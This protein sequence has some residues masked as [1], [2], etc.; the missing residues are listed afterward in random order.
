MTRLNSLSRWA[1]AVAVIATLGFAA[2]V[3]LSRDD[4]PSSSGITA[5]VVAIDEVRVPARDA[6]QLIEFSRDISGEGKVVAKGDLLGHI[7][8]SDLKIKQKTAAAQVESAKNS[9]KSQD[10]WKAA[11]KTKEL[12]HTEWKK[13]LELNEKNPRTVANF[14]VQRQK[15][16]YDKAGHEENVAAIK[17]A[18]A[19]H[20]V[21]EK[22]AELEYV[23]NQISR[24]QIIA[25]ISGVITKR[26]R[27]E[28]EWVQAGE[29][30]ITIVYMDRVRV[31]IGLQAKEY[32]PAQVLGK[33]VTITAKVPGVSNYT[34][35]GKVEF[36]SEIISEG[37]RFNVWLDVENKQV[38]GF[39]VL[40][41]GLDVDV[42][43]GVDPAIAAPE[44]SPVMRPKAR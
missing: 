5:L 6:G 42:T 9:A 2:N 39:W 16:Q 27:H 14:E 8:S 26:E 29:P 35:T 12:A 33:P 36:A 3:A 32:S 13:S 24:R 23:K 11:T 43:L 25:P 22:E 28:G 18:N 10:E 38:D 44:K 41:P 20:T 7:D 17:Y 4:N 31:V 37:D 19:K 40:R 15:L 34:F 21:H 1:L 30:I